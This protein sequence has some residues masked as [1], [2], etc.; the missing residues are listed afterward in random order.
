MR[1]WLILLNISIAAIVV[2]AQ[3]VELGVML[4]GSLYSG[5]LSPKEFG[6]YFEEV[7][8]AG[9]IFGRFNLNNTLSLHLGAS[10]GN[11]TG[12]GDT[13]ETVIRPSF[14]SNIIEV[15]LTGEISPFTL[16]NDN[17]LVK[18]YLFGGGAVYRFN[19]QA[20]FDGNW[21]DLQSLGTEGQGLEGYQAPYNLT[22][23]AIPF[24][25]GI[26][27][28]INDSWAIGM[29]FGWRKTFTDYLDDISDVNV[30][31]LDVYEGNG[32]IA[33]QISNALITG[34]ENGDV[35]YKRGGEYRDWYHI[36]GITVSYFL[37]GSSGYNG[38]VSS[39]S[40]SIGGG[41]KRG[42]GIGCPTF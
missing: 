10:L 4:G 31:Y 35:N 37:S 34:P 2:Q 7:N 18:P 25:G 36:G 33:A 16:G 12:S 20:P 11:M 9:G 39:R 14:R 8:P 22:Q 23:F 41:R 5:D 3:S 26:K 42:K 24:G 32:S 38:G 13:T 1:K 19:P 29:E 40:S 21:I 15:A 27:F 6:V 17:F 30:N 28:I